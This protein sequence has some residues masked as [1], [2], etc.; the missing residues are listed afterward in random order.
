MMQI[1][2]NEGYISE[3]H[4]TI[5]SPLFPTYKEVCFEISNI[6]NGFSYFRQRFFLICWIILH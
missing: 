3:K 4:L 1:L 2:L 5:M 6:A